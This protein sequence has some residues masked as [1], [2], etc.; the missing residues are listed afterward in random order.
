MDCYRQVDKEKCKTK[1]EWIVT[2]EDGSNYEL[3]ERHKNRLLDQFLN[4]PGL[5]RPVKFERKIR[6]GA[7]NA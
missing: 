3:C 5:F 6:E 2:R 7:R 1:T 4:H